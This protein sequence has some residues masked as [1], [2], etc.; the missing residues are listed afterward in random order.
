MEKGQVAEILWAESVDSDS[1]LSPLVIKNTKL[2]DS[3]NFVK[4]I[5]KLKWLS[6]VCPHLS[7]LFP[8]CSAHLKATFTIVS[9]RGYDTKIYIAKLVAENLAQFCCV[10]TVPL[11]E[12]PGYSPG[13]IWNR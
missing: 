4:Q 12:F 11:P 13:T 6:M 8:G 7:S 10:P 1:E 2:W 5:R 9:K 3:F